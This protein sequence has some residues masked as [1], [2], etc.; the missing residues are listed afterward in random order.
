MMSILTNAAAM[1][2]LSSLTSTQTQLSKTQ[3]QISSGLAI[4]TASDNAAYWSIGQTMS[5]QVVGLK[6]VNQSLAVTGGI[7]NVTSAALLAIKSSVQKIQ[8]DIVIAKQAGVSRTAVQSDISAQQQSIL[9]IACSASFNGVNWLVNDVSS[10]YSRKIDVEIDTTE[11][12]FDLLLNGQEPGASAHFE[13]T[14]TES[15]HTVQNGSSSDSTTVSGYKQTVS[16]APDGTMTN[17]SIPKPDVTV[18]TGDLPD[19]AAVRI[20][21]S[22]SASNG[23]VISTFSTAPINLFTDYSGSYTEEDVSNFS[24][25]PQNST[26]SGPNTSS[27][28]YSSYSMGDNAGSGGILDGG[29]QVTRVSPPS[30]TSGSSSTTSSSPPSTTI[31]INPSG[32]SIHNNPGSSGVTTETSSPSGP[33]T[34]TMYQSIVTLSVVGASFDEL[35]DMGAAV[36]TALERL[37]T[38]SGIVGALQTR[39]SNQEAFNTSLSDAL[40]SGVG[41]LLDADMNVASTRLQALQTQQQ[42]GLQALSMANNNSQLILKLFQAA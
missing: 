17:P 16:D 25:D 21:I 22:V 28:G 23:T 6:A 2:A 30:G 20:P 42:L 18:S 7:A 3:A 26:H 11:S 1:S 9:A 24:G 10:D 19:I 29:V 8:D 32:G 36:Q 41:S 27:N 37:T 38:A 5:A 40:T 4:G 34:Y 15:T 39:I 13:S 33:T 35:T 12:D 31:A 14:I